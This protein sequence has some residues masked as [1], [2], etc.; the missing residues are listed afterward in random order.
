[1]GYAGCTCWCARVRTPRPRV[2]ERYLTERYSQLS[3]GGTGRHTRLICGVVA[4]DTPAARELMR[5]LPET[6]LVGGDSLAA[7][8]TVRDVLRLT[9]SEPSR[10]Q[11]GGE[12]VATRLADILV[13]HAVR[14]WLSANPDDISGWMRALQ[15]GRIGSALEAIHN[16]PGKEWSLTGLAQLATMSRSSFS[17]RFTELVGTSPIAYLARWRMSVAESRLAEENT[18]TS[19]LAAELGYQSEA[20]FSRAFARITGRTPGSVRSERRPAS[21]LLPASHSG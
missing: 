5:T 7:A 2:A 15:D 16:A 17:A 4:F 10:P 11:P 19:E 14:G 3:Y 1:M 12:T 18:V 13:V 9:A 20:A 8:S 21:A 6:L